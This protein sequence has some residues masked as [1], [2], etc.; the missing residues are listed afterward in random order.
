MS[1]CINRCLKRF[2]LV[3]FPRYYA[4]AATSRVRKTALNPEIAQAKKR[5]SRK[6]ALPRST[7]L[8]S[9]EIQKHL[10]QVA[11]TNGHLVLADI[12]R[13]RPPVHATPGTPV[14]K[15][16]YTTLLKKINDSFNVK[17]LRQFMKFY[18]IS[19]PSARAKS[20]CSVAIMD[21]WGWPS[22]TVLEEKERDSEMDVETIPL[23]PCEAF[24][25]L[26]KDGV[27]SRSLSIQYHV[28]M[29]Y[30]AN[31]LSLQVEGKVGSLRELKKH[32]AGLKEEI[33]D[34]VFEL[35][36]GKPIKSDLLR[37]ISRL[38][39]ALTENFGENKIRVSFNKN[40]SR[41]AL[42]AKRLAARAVCEDNGSNQTQ[43]L[44][45]LPPSAPSPSPISPFL[46][47][48]A[49]YPFLS[50]RSL[51]WT[52]NTSGV[53]RVRRV[54]KWLSSGGSE[55]LKKTGGLLMGRGHLVTTQQQET[56]LRTMLLGD[57][58]S[59][60]SSRV[61]TASIGHILLSSPSGREVSL[62][63]PLPLQGQWKLSHLLGWMEQQSASTV[64]SPTL[65][66]ILINSR[67]V[68]PRILHR[69]VYH[70]GNNTQADR[71]ILKVELVLPR[72]VKETASLPDPS[73]ESSALE[74]PT[75]HAKCWS[76]QEV[77]IDVLMPDRPADIRFSILESIVLPGDQWPTILEEYISNLRAFLTY[78][79]REASQPE[80]PLTFVHQGAIY[81]LHSSSTVRQ[82]TEPTETADPSSVQLVTESS[83]DLEGDQKFASCQVICNDLESETSWNSFLRY[84]DSMST[85]AAPTMPRTAPVL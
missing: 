24:L 60:S 17:Q 23:T 74:E 72:S 38:S 12:E 32:I 1:L 78:Q 25:I 65:P 19:L 39:G 7:V 79:D 53:F 33:A 4:S 20:E 30:L 52:V 6:K 5:A 75:F 22:L 71:K 69:L 48:Y 55:D 42:V 16:E 46:H 83:L 66:T 26:G 10:T 43:T 11:E 21:H 49:L 68:Q 59:P 63:P 29:T 13:C 85:S 56:D 34:D 58:D 82:N 61:V 67:P 9:S 18:G 51:P 44:F 41:T 27:D 73:N 57:S 8:D 80:T 36:V 76:G 81:V 54:E 40:N 31:P 3:S 64:F 15:M 37:R 47:D 77:D 28:R 62:A 50:P 14:Y 35:P 45:Y 2:P 84:C 70:A